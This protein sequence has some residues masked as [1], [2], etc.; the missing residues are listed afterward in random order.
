MVKAQL[1]V[2][3]CDKDK[4]RIWVGEATQARE[5]VMLGAAGYN[6]LCA[7]LLA[8]GYQPVLVRRELVAEKG[9]DLITLLDEGTLT[10]AKRYIACI[11]ASGGDCS[12][13]EELASHAEE[14]HREVLE[15]LSGRCS[16]ADGMVAV[17]RI[18]AT[19]MAKGGGGAAYWLM[20]NHLLAAVAVR[21]A[22]SRPMA[23]MTVL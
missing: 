11:S 14:V 1:A 20:V 21:D 15:L 7:G 2:I 12:T 6:A 8:D 9:G 23:K 17:R 22:Y 10:N 5:E 4:Y 18:G 19:A 16:V 3:I 13:E